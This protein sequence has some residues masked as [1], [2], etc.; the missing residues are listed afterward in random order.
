[1]IK[2]SLVLLLIGYTYSTAVICPDADL[3]APCTCYNKVIDPMRGL[4]A[5]YMDCTAPGVNASELQRI[6]KVPFI[7]P[8][9]DNFLLSQGSNFRPDYDS[10]ITELGDLFVNGVTFRTVYIDN[11]R[12]LKRITSSFLENS[13]LFLEELQVTRTQIDEDNFPFRTLG[14]YLTLNA[15]DLENNKFTRI[16]AIS[17]AALKSISFNNNPVTSIS[18]GFNIDS[19]KLVSVECAYCNLTGLDA[20]TFYIFGTS[21]IL[22]LVAYEFNFMNNDNLAYVD[23][24]AFTF[25]NGPINELFLG[26]MDC[27]VTNLAPVPYKNLLDSSKTG[28][29]YFGDT[30]VCNCTMTWLFDTPVI[31]TVPYKY[32]IGGTCAQDP[33]VQI[34]QLTSSMFQNCSSV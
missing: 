5:S 12:N 33:D 22:N 6:F 20:D 29:I 7:Q 10:D 31:S 17:N 11:L 21:S 15:V 34:R 3:I 19:P 16:P 32:R 18:Q 14:D 25:L 26:L 30:L 13:T 2:S 4:T 24:D 23:P 8:Q 28:S 27:Q 9:M 1:M